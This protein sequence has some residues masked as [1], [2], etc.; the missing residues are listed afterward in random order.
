MGQAGEEAGDDHDDVKDDG[1][2]AVDGREAG[3]QAK[4]DEEHGRREEPVDVSCFSESVHLGLLGQAVYCYKWLTR[5]VNLSEEL[6]EFGVLHAGGLDGNV[7][8]AL[9]VGHGKVG[10]HGGAENGSRD[11]AFASAIPFFFPAGKKAC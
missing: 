9:V 2:Q 3:K 4:R 6:V 1:E 10:E 5:P 8:N 11:P 7:R